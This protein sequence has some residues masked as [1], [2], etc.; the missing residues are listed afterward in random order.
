[1]LRAQFHPPRAL[2]SPPLAADNGNLG[3]VEGLPPLVFAAV[4]KDCP[5]AFKGCVIVG[6][7]GLV[8][9]PPGMCKQGLLPVLHVQ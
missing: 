3:H 6:G 4:R 5:H 8:E 9:D 2:V 7:I 1:M